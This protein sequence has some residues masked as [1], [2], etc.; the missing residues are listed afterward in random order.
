MNTPKKT[1]TLIE[2][3][4]VAIIV[5]ILA[6]VAIPLMTGNVQRAIITEAEAALGTI[7][8]NMRAGYSEYGEY[9]LIENDD[10]DAISDG[11][12]AVNLRP[13]SNTDLDG[14][15]F[16]HHCYLIEAVDD[17]TF[18]LKADGTLSD[19]TVAPASEKV[20]QLEVTMDQA[21]TI[22]LSTD[23]GATFE[24]VQ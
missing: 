8:S 12:V 3:M 11:E 9:D 23:D 15:Y 20:G 22:R 5:A 16:S 17:D 1:F 14:H 21:G 13:I 19:D 18:T 7:R 10:G 4:V 24:D 6:A 2:L